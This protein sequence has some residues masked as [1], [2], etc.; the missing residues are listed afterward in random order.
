MPIFNFYRFENKQVDNGPS[1]FAAEE[2]AEARFNQ[3]KYQSPRECFGSFFTTKQR[4]QLSVMKTHGSA[5]EHHHE[6]YN[7]D[8]VVSARQDVILLELENNGTKTTIENK[9]RVKHP[10]HPYC[11]VIIDN[12]EGY[13]IIAIEKNAAFSGDTDKAALVLQNGFNQKLSVYGREIVI[14]PLH[15]KTTDFWPVVWDIRKKFNDHVRF[16]K[17][18]FRGEGENKSADG[19][20]SLITQLAQKGDCAALLELSRKP[21]SPEINLQELHD[22]LTNIAAICH[23]EG[24]FDLT[25]HFA[26]F[27]CY[28]YGADIMAQFGIEEEAINSFGLELLSGFDGNGPTFEL[29]RWMDKMN[30]ILKDYANTGI[31][32]RG[33]KKG[34]RRKAC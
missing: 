15:K 10:N 6:I 32:K 26:H 3:G 19:L 25:V 8:V 12:R 13:Q 11:R 1:L 9:K 31:L 20:M 17:L 2:A 14:Q 5:G 16:I 21:G 30:E 34:P 27:G 29:I 33:R 18:D 24:I 7:C 4:H 28:R 22:D 23:D